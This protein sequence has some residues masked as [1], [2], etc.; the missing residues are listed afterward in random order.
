MAGLLRFDQPGLA[1]S[2]FTFFSPT[3]VHWHRHFRQT[4]G[5]PTNEGQF[6]FLPLG[7]VDAAHG[8]IALDTF[9]GNP[10]WVFAPSGL[11]PDALESGKRRRDALSGNND[12]GESGPTTGL[13]AG[14]GAAVVN[15]RVYVALSPPVRDRGKQDMLV[16]LEQPTGQLFWRQLLPREIMPTSLA[17]S[18]DHVFVQIAPP[19]R[20]RGMSQLAAFRLDNGK[21]EWTYPIRGGGST[22]LAQGLL[23]VADGDLRAFAP[24]ERTFRLAIDTD[25]PSRYRDTPLRKPEPKEGEPIA[26]VAEP[27]EPETAKAPD[28]EG[29]LADATVLRL[30][31][32]GDLDALALQIRQRRQAAPR[33]PLLLSLDWTRVDSGV[34]PEGGIPDAGELAFRC[35]RLAAAGAPEYLDLAPEI[36]VLLQRN[37]EVRPAV[38]AL[39]ARVAM[40][41]RQA[42]P[43]TS[44]LFS[45][46]VEVLRRIY[47]N[48]DLQPLGPVP[49]REEDDAAFY[50]ELA[51][52]VDAVGLASDPQ[53]A[54]RRASD[55]P[56]DYFL[57]LRKLFGA[58][59]LVVTR[60]AVRYS[61]VV[62][63]GNA[64][65]NNYLAR[66]LQACYWLDAPVVAYPQLL[67]T[68][69]GQKAEP[70]ALL[71][72]T[73][74]RPA[75]AAWLH[76][77]SWERVEQLTLATLSPT[78]PEQALPR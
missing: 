34:L 15:G 1:E 25:D 22:A 21:L 61:E 3:G 8:I 71:A 45:V 42:S 35:A 67:A 54:F 38:R 47:G 52:L 55:V 14:N 31:P 43:A 76:A 7:G 59:P 19:S 56:G 74:V 72:R 11:V 77:R 26:L 16:A 78:A 53:A 66:L 41:V 27:T 65:P 70:E 23:F 58:K 6:I 9:G 5:V 13:W 50:A 69:G 57:G 4:L 75:L 29:A 51:M 33:L 17:A 62:L 49:R 12:I 48:G 18:K 10:V 46:N 32:R 44:V 40:A 68:P 36:N 73:T 30:D 60:L 37:P 39:V 2:L 24:A 20:L 28:S 63:H 64:D